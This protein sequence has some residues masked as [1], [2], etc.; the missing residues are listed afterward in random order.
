MTIVNEKDLFAD[1]LKR[2]KVLVDNTMSI[3]AKHRS[4]FGIEWCNAVSGCSHTDD[5]SKHRPSASDCR[6]AKVNI[7]SR[8]EG[9]PIGGK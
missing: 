1:R 6:Q 2:E 8:I 4:S 3:C 9:F 5:D 7:C